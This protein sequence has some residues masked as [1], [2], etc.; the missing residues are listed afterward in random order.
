M[1]DDAIALALERVVAPQRAKNARALTLV[2]ALA[3]G[4]FFATALTGGAVDD[5]AQRPLLGAY[6]L[7][8]AILALVV[9]RSKRAL[10]HSWVA[11]ALVDL[12][13]ISAIQWVGLP[14]LKVPRVGVT[15]TA[16]A[17]MLVILAAL[18]SM[19]KRYVFSTA[20]AAVGLLILLSWRAGAGDPSLWMRSV[21]LLVF[22]GVFAAI[23]AE[24]VRSLVARSANDE[25]LRD[26][27]GRYF[28]PGVRDKILE[29]GGSSTLG[30]Q[31]EVTV[32]FAD[33]RGFTSMS[34]NMASTDVVT[35]LN[36]YLSAMVEIIFKHGGTLDKFMGDGIM[37]YFGAPIARTDHATAAVACALDM[38]TALAS[39][40]VT[41]RT[42][43][44]A[45]L[46]IGIG[47]NSGPVVVG[48]IG[49]EH[50]REYTCIGDTV[51]VAS[52]IETLTKAHGATVL[53]S[54]E[55]KRLAGDA[56]FTWLEAQAVS[57][58]GKTAKVK[59]WVPMMPRSS[60]VPVET[61]APL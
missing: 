2:R 25:L 33:I 31:R 41:R 52:R 4:V 26:R 29:A 48:D 53:A 59:T 50:R 6:V 28:S 55:T 16:G 37:A 20:G 8:S 54:E 1:E 56:A 5:V 35:M 14:L 21:L 19:Q 10:A 3:A 32:L 38:V 12:P 49:S 23:I 27:L 57:V 22:C 9:R 45:E 30:E 46:H 60:R 7:V 17:F 36:E 43:G 15:F 18:L 42:R 11:L 24:Q 51:N 58:R 47:I 61:D 40:N 13:L 39:L 34:E 44:E